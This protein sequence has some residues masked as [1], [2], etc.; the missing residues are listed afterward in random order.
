M[1]KLAVLEIKFDFNGD[2]NT[3]YPVILSDKS[4]VILIDC[5]YPNF[6]HL[7]KGAAKKDGVDIS[8]LTKIIITHHDFDHMGAL[9][10][11]KRE[12]PHIKVLSSIDDEKYIS[13]KEKSLRLQQ[14][15]AIYDKIPE[16]EK[17]SAKEFQRFIQK[18]ENVQVDMCLKDRDSFSWF[19]GME[20]IATPGHMPGH[21]SVYLESSKTLISGDALIV[22]N[23]KLMIPYPQ[24]TLDI[25]N[26]KKSI[27]KLLN[28]EIDR[29]ICYHGGT[30]I[31]DI[32]ESL[33]SI[34]LD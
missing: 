25:D 15:E 6:L 13:G 2:K 5:G 24:Y 29:I 23:D 26:A 9:A 11:F 12:Y 21:I 32:K 27:N 14:A 18:V 20:I 10:E 17:E 19:G 4:E 1:N 8:K 7:I 22:E 34:I 33:Q 28:Y 16:E 30:Y 31:K 3:I